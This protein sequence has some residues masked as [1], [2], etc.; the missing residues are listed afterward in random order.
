[1]WMYLWALWAVQDGAE[2][3]YGTELDGRQCA[4]RPGQ[5]LPCLSGAFACRRK[6]LGYLWAI[7]GAEELFETDVDNEPVNSILPDLDGCFHV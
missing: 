5:L 1:M 3:F 4:A 2:E 7:H 6:N